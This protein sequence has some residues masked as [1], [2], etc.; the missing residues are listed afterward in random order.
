LEFGSVGFYGRRK[1]LRARREPSTNST[2]MPINH[3]NQTWV[4]EVAGKC[5]HHYASLAPLASL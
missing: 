1:T 3:W 4:T 5:S 2:H